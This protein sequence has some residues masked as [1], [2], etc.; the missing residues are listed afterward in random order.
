M[1]STSI[2]DNTDLMKS[3]RMP[4]IDASNE[5]TSP[6]DFS[7]KGLTVFDDVQDEDPRKGQHKLRRDK[8]GKYL[9]T[10]LKFNNNAL[11]DMN[12][13]EPVVEGLLLKPDE[14][15]WLD[16]SMNDL[17][18]ID[19]VIL[20]FK[21]LKMLYLHGNGISDHNQVDKLAAFPNLIT[22]TLHGNPLENEPGYRQLILA[23]LPNLRSLDFSR[24]TKADRANASIWK[25]MIG[26][27]K[28]KRRKSKDE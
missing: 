9:C 7:F 23:K 19:P 13:F 2:M 1:G 11:T 26:Q 3:P 4:A 27:K 15:L 21:N 18:N 16:L 12:N 25:T 17:T 28:R 20:M 24:V 14:L 5:I 6:L 10:S 22:L 8:G